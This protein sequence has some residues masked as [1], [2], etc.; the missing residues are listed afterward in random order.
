MAYVPAAPNVQPARQVCTAVSHRHAGMP[1]QHDWAARAAPLW[2][3][4][5]G[6]LHMFGYKVS[7]EYVCVCVW[8]GADVGMWVWGVKSRLPCSACRG[9][10]LF[11]S[12]RPS[13]LV[14]N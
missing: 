8:F 6:G 7:K 11:S 3:C 14:S 4:H 13:C 2:R 1:F 5:F 12:R 9:C 10:G